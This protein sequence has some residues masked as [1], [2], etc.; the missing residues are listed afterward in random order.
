MTP[1]NAESKNILANEKGQK[2]F[3]DIA[4]HLGENIDDEDSVSQI[5]RISKMIKIDKTID[6]D[7]INPKVQK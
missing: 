7:K 5:S 4:D 3:Q 1:S 2:E 6:S